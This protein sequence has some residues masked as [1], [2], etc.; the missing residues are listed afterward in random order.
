MA[1]WGTDHITK[2]S[3]VIKRETQLLHQHAIADLTA[4]KKS[5]IDELQVTFLREMTNQISEAMINEKREFNAL[6]MDT[7]TTSNRH[8]ERSSSCLREVAAELR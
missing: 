5:L 7:L 4:V 8:L 1:S 3:N 6:V 2:L